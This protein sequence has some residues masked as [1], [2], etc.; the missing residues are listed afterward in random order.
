MARATPSAPSALAVVRVSGPGVREVLRRIAPD[1]PDPP[2][3]RKAVLASLLDPGDGELLDRG[4]VTY[5]PRPESY[6]GEDVAEVSCH[7]GAVAPALVLDACLRAGCREAEPGEFTR[8]AYLHGKMDLVQAEAVLDLVEGR[9]RA[10]HRAALRQ[11]DRGL[12]ER[13]GRVREALVEVEALL[14]H[15]L[16]FPEEDDAPVPVGRVLERARQV[17]TRL[18]RLAATAPEGELLREGALTVLA[19]RPN[20]GKS[21]LFNALL[22]RERAI[23]TRVAGTT[24]DALE[25]EVSLGGFPFRLVDTAGLREPGEEVERLGIEVAR[26]YVDAADLVLVCMED[27]RAPTAEEEDFLQGLEGR[28]VVVVRTKADLVEGEVGPVAGVHDGISGGGREAESPGREAECSGGPAGDSVVDAAVRVSV[29]DGTGLERLREV[30]PGLVYRGL[31]RAD[32]D[33]PVLTNQRQVERIREALDEV[34][35]FVRALEGG[36]PAEVA[37]AHLRAAE[38]AL[39]GLLG[40]VAADDVLEHLFRRFCIGK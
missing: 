22:G 12:S 9:S 30:L 24:R 27:G 5:F 13:V 8:R 15:H 38:S 18:R 28:P 26:R 34:E 16:D 36:V 39:E 4:L 40:I 33:E 37:A 25:A 31:V 3:A 10:L 23:V 6:T 21:S 35:G 20:S 14:A 29:V 19:G 32:P 7:G 11:M 1:L 17:A 2:P